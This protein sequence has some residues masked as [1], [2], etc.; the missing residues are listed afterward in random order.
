MKR[1]EK[2]VRVPA[3]NRKPAEFPLCST[4]SRAAARAMVLAR[5]EKVRPV[6]YRS[7]WAKRQEH[8]SPT[9]VYDYETGL[10]VS[11]P[12]VEIVIDGDENTD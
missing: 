2:P 1:C 8:P 7:D 12:E 6:V 4:E 10:P 11:T 5:S 3:T 9:D